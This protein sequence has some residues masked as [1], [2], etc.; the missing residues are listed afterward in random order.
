MMNDE[1]IEVQV[2]VEPTR[3][4]QEPS[5]NVVYNTKT[6]NQPVD[7]AVA[8]IEESEEQIE[9]M[10]NHANSAID[11]S[12]SWADDGPQ[13]ISQRSPPRREE[14]NANEMNSQMVKN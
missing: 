9:A 11:L 2:D 7:G 13:C 14:F 10:R 5:K 8:N 12:D 1:H 3:E 4:N 6:A